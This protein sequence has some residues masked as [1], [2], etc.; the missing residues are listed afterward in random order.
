MQLRKGDRVMFADSVVRRC[1]RDKA[2]ADMRGHIVALVSGGRVAIVET[3]GTYTADD[4]RTERA[5]PAANLT[6]A[7]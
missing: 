5:I 6:P 2:V 3:N 7:I 4:G 1:G